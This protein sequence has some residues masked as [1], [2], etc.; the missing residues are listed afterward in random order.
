MSN[1][2]NSEYAL[3]DTCE[4]NKNVPKYYTMY[5]NQSNLEQKI[6]IIFIESV[7]TNYKFQGRHIQRKGEDIGGYS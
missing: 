2:I 5:Y 3:S 4:T 1:I 7:Q 6:F